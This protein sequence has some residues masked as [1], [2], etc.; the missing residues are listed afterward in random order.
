MAKIVILT[1]LTVEGEEEGYEPEIATQP[2][3]E[4]EESEQEESTQSQ[5][6][7]VYRIYRIQG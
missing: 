1:C 7:S 6:P 5:K 2:L 3:L 4:S